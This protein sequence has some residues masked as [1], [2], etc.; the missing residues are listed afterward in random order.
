MAPMSI[1]RISLSLPCMNQRRTDR[2]RFDVFLGE[3]GSLS[4]NLEMI[5]QINGLRAMVCKLG[6]AMPLLFSLMAMRSARIS[7]RCRIWTATHGLG[8]A[9]P[10]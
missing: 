3:R 10:C 5:Q 2:L 8:C 1:F 4:I 9:I 7:T 6:Y